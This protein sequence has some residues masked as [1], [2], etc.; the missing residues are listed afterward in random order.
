MGIEVGRKLARQLEPR[1]QSWAPGLCAKQRAGGEFRRVGVVSQFWP[2]TILEIFPS[3]WWISSGAGLDQ[4][5]RSS[6][7]AYMNLEPQPR[8]TLQK[9]SWLSLLCFLEPNDRQ[10]RPRVEKWA[11]LIVSLVQEECN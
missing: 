10:V 2:R 3:R 4:T 7:V 6:L 11:G 9:P 8:V 5:I 1:W